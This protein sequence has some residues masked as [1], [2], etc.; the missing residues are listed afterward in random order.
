[1]GIYFKPKR[2]YGSKTLWVNLISIAAIIV[3]AQTGKEIISAELQL[4]ILSLVNLLLRAITKEKIE[5]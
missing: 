2:W 3:Q 1:M 5:W 4:T